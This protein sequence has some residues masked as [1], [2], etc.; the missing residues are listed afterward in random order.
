MIY[1]RQFKHLE[2]WA[3]DGMRV[4]WSYSETWILLFWQDNVQAM[5]MGLYFIKR[6]PVQLCQK[7]Q[8]PY[9]YLQ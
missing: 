2:N 9:E 5:I 8:K 4:P 7:A 6:A 1:K 3:A